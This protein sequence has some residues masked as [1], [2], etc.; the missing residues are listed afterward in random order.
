MIFKK[1]DLKKLYKPDN[2]SSGEDNGQVTIIGGSDLFHGAPLF[3]VKLASKIVDMVFFSTPEKSVGHVAEQM[4]SKL[5]SFIWVPWEDTEDY[6]KKSDA[7][8]IGQGFKRF[9]SEKIGHGDR[10][11]VCDE[12]C[13]QT[14][15]ITEKFLKS[16]PDKK[17]VIDAGSLQTLDPDW[18]PQNSILT[19]NQKELQN[20]FGEMSPNEAS[21][22]YKC[23]IVVK[24]PT[25]F[26]YSDD[27]V[28]EVNGGNAG[29]TKGGS[30][31]VMAGL[32]TALL[33][34]NEP[35]L[36]ASAAA[37]ITKSA[38]DEL[39]KDVGVNYNSD[40]LVDMIPKVL[41]KLLES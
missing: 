12:D 37:Y 6:I 35:L 8:L 40:D 10:F 26:V 30:G 9:K 2:D 21:K 38:A 18:I 33:A 28:I 4:K 20:L 36:A 24:G 13:L 27:E 22:R 3:S 34:K 1:E 11:N 31:D 23:V 32:T 41:N 29:L 15:S 17:W 25:T 14:K 39:Y 7:V 19:P 5:L 16:F